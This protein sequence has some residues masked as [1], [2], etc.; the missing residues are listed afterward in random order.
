M[1]TITNK[2][3]LSILLSPVS[4]IVAVSSMLN[5]TVETSMNNI[6]H[7]TTLFSHDNPVNSLSLYIYMER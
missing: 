6:V 5:N 7:S 2:I 3:V 4:T 1:I